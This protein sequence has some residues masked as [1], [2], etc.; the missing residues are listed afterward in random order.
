LYLIRDTV[1]SHRVVRGKFP[2]VFEIM[3]PVSHDP[4]PCPTPQRQQPVVRCAVYARVSV[5]GSQAGEFNSMQAQ[6]WACERCIAERAGRG[7]TLTVPTFTGD[8]ES[9]KD[10]E[11]PGLR[12]L[13]ALVE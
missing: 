2:R 7:W 12:P 6:V 11:R 9:A 4:T 5:S 3:W 10:L 1:K 13:I 8:G